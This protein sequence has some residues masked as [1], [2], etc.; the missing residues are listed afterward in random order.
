[1]YYVDMFF[2]TTVCANNEDDVFFYS[3]Q[4]QDS[5]RPSKTNADPRNANLVPLKKENILHCSYV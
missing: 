5:K 1:M 2:L 4:S 3:L